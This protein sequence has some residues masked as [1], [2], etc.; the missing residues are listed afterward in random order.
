MGELSLPLIS[1]SIL[2]SV[3]YA[4]LGQDSRIGPE[5]ISVEELTLRMWK[6]VELAL[7]LAHSCKR[8]ANHGS[9]EELTLVVG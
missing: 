5:V 8:R 4:T 7:P 9:A 6:V 2:E 3:P 1:Y